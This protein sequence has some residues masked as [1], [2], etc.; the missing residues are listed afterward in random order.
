VNSVAC[1]PRYVYVGGGKGIARFDKLMEHWETPVSR[2]PFP[3]DIRLI[4]ID[5]GGNE[6]WFTTPRSLGR[7]NPVFE[8]YRI[9][10]F[11]D[12]Y[13]SPCSL[14][15][16]TNSVYLWNSRQ[17][18]GFDKVRNE[19]KTLQSL[20][21][22]AEW[23]P[24]VSPS[25]R[26]WLAP[27]YV[28]DDKLN[29]YAMTCATEDG[30][31]VWV[32]TRGRGLYKYSAVTFMA[33]SYVLGISGERGIA[34]LREGDHIWVGTPREIVKWEVTK[35]LST[36]Y[37]PFNQ[38][39]ISESD[40]S[41]IFPPEAT[42]MV[43]DGQ[44]MWLGTG[45]GLFQFEKNSGDWRR[46]SSE[47]VTA[48]SVDGEDV[49][50]GTQRGLA[51][52]R[53]GKIEQVFEDVW[54][55]DVKAGM[56][57]VWVATSRGV[58]RKSGDEWSEFEDPDKILPHGV[59]RISVDGSR[60]YFGTTNQG[61]L[62]HEAGKWEKFNYPV[63]LPGER[64]LSIASDSREL[65]VGTDAGV[66]IWEKERNFWNRYSEDNSPIKGKVYSISLG[67]DNVYFGTDAGMVQFKR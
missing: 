17:C 57:T 35:G 10:D 14:G 26:P 49:W 21:T 54:V 65:C 60:T 12:G 3:D 64:I 32:G 7:Y 66:A 56:N 27:Y 63:H 45:Q 39:N 40:M 58:I 31:Y 29:Q 15:I 30:Q 33:E 6:V 20:P 34:M 25:Q 13:T 19:W 52:L 41:G 5:M 44:R 23:S 1:D 11:P 37:L 47:G 16:G 2:E 24:K 22:D 18:M 9:A 50:I 51:K 36:Y 55:N 4:A 28:M 67:K 53:A 59:Y 61:L 48:L 8:N 38:F 62:V 43:S 42:S 46:L